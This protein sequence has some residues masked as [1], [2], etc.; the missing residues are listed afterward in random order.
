MLVLHELPQLP[1]KL[2]FALRSVFAR[3]SFI[4][5]CSRHARRLRVPPTGS[6]G[7]MRLAGRAG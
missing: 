3:A 7:H 5:A 1:D 4:E 6:I 2:I